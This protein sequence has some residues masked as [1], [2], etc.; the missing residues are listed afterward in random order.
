MGRDGVIADKPRLRGVSHQWAAIFAVPLGV[1]LVIAAGGSRARAAVAVYA[2]SLVALFAVSAFYHRV[3]WRSLVA[4]RRMRRLDH[5]MIFVLIA[6]TYTPVAVVAIRG[7]AGVAILAVAWTGALSGVVV[8]LAW[9]TAPRWLVVAAY[10]G[11]GWIAL[12]A[13]PQLV[14]AIGAVGLGLLA[15]GGL[16]YTGGAVVYALRRPDPAPGVFGYHEVFHAMV[17]VAAL[18]QYAVIAF[19]VLPR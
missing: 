16:L 7:P 1:A 4:L 2:I 19:W 6:A 14:A 18:V 8:K 15:L 11:L 5:S 10:I 9:I 13:I 12:A 17:I 3:N